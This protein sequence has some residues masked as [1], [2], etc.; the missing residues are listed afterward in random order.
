M[1]TK[2]GGNQFHGD[3][4]GF[5]EG[6][7]LQA[8]NT[9]GAKLPQTQTTTSNTA[10]RADDGG[11]L[12]GFLVK[13]KLWFFG[14]YNRV[15]Q[16]DEAT[17]IRPLGRARQPGGRQHRAADISK[18]L[19][20]AKVTFKLSQNHTFTATVFGDPTTATARS[21]RRQRPA[22]RHLR[23]G[24]HLAG[25]ARSGRRRLPSAATTASSAT[26]CCSA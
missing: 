17:I 1:I 24:Q 23:A 2:S 16:R 25:H 9:T 22:V 13:D 4:F 18:N 20:A 3:V 15:D 8:A 12:G 10:H 5:G 6:G 14:A 19:F 11:D 26:R 7:G 21:S